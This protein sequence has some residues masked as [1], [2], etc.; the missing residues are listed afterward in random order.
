MGY[1]LGCDNNI[2]FWVDEWIDDCIF[3][4][5]YPHIYAIAINKNLSV[6]EFGS[7]TNSS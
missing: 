5:C 2:K 3:Y 1:S 7:W 4:L 6:F